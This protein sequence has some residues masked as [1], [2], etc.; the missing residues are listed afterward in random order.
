MSAVL[1]PRVILGKDAVVDVGV[2]VREGEVVERLDFVDRDHAQA[3]LSSSRRDVPIGSAPS[4]P[5]TPPAP[6]AGAS[7]DAPS[8]SRDQGR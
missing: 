4:P 1:E 5:S 8:S 7:Q 3:A 6:A 2:T